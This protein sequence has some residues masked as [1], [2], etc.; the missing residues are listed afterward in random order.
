MN[1]RVI[2]LDIIRA[3]A[4][5]LVL[6]MHS[7]H[8]LDPLLSVPVLGIIFG[9]FKALTTPFGFLGVELFFVLSG[10]LIGTILIK[11]F[12]NSK[13]HFIEEV[14]KFW[15]KRWFRTLPLYYL[16]L[17]ANYF[18]YE[19][20]SKSDFNFKYLLFVHNFFSIPPNFFPESWSLAVEEWFYLT[21]PIFLIITS[22][23]SNPKSKQNILLLTLITYL[24]L[25]TLIRIYNGFYPLYNNYWDGGVRKIVVLRLDA[26]MYGVLCAYLIYFHKEFINKYTKQLL[27]FGICGLVL[28][29]LFF[30]L[31][32][33][34][35]LN[36]YLKYSSY[37]FFANTFLFSFISLFFC[38]TIPYANNIT[39]LNNRPLSKVITHISLIS[40]S[41]YLI[42]YSIIYI[43]FFKEHSNVSPL[44]SI[45][46]FFLYLFLVLFISSLLYFYYERPMLAIRDKFTK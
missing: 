43:P 31:G 29:V 19:I 28:L 38:L 18:I 24:L 21:L 30:Y 13:Q 26:V 46:L 40:Y 17:V 41:I 25:F 22:Y 32:I 8:I 15:I 1:N 35:N 5:L 6:I 34:P 14:K 20:F 45:C 36:F 39:T 23:F 42:H 44:I 4:I 33:H 9:K 27:W 3:T 37:R 12:M 10:F 7:I 2:G 11:V 16:I